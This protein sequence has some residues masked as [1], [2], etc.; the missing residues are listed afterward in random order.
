MSE[1][2]DTIMTGEAVAIEA[3]PAS[4]MTRALSFLIDFVFFATVLILLLVLTAD[5]WEGL[6]QAQMQTIAIV[7]LAT[8]LVVV[9]TSIETA[10][11][12]RS[13]G[14]VVLGTR[15]VRDDGGPISFRHAITRWSSGFIELFLSFGMIA[16]TVSSL[17]KRSKRLGDMMAGTYVA[18]IGG[19][20]EIDL[21]ILC[22]PE[23]EAWA[24]HADM[25]ALPDRVSLYSRKYLAR[26]SS[27]TPERR[28]QLG[29]QLAAELEKYVAPPPPAGTHPERFLAAVLATRRDREY[30]VS[31]RRQE[32]DRAEMKVLAALPHG[33]RD[34]NN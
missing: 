9:P 25:R 22:P 14:K 7:M 8:L 3:R 1:S 18:R 29:L 10:T 15:V 23:L 32:A 30:L 13:L 34:A 20:E 17:N 11:R 19:T 2:L 4:V 33:V 5:A 27:M 21:P 16:F 26:T 28:Q 12:G 31:M 24:A 6:N